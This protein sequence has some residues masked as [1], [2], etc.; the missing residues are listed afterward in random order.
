MLEELERED[1]QVV[2]DSGGFSDFE[3]IADSAYEPDYLEALADYFEA[4]FPD[5]L[6]PLPDDTAQRLADYLRSLTVEAGPPP[7]DLLE[8][9]LTTLRT[10]ALPVED[11][12]AFPVVEESL[13]KTLFPALKEVEFPPLDPDGV[14]GS[15]QA[16]TVERKVTSF[17][18]WVTLF[19]IIKETK[20]RLTRPPG[21][22]PSKKSWR[23]AGP[24]ELIALET[25]H[26]NR[27]I[28][29]KNSPDPVGFGMFSKQIN[30]PLKTDAITAT[31]SG[32][33]LSVGSQKVPSLQ[34][35]RTKRHGEVATS[36]VGPMHMHV[37]VLFTPLAAR[38]AKL[39]VTT[40]NPFVQWPISL[41]KNKTFNAIAAI[42][43]KFYSAIIR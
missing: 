41:L 33:M 7:E 38:I 9:L 28:Q 10:H 15:I 12:P 20:A 36:F 19:R 21:L 6:P 17:R 3:P 31:L 8:E 11:C 22:N 42:E 30:T 18:Q 14:E 16:I 39:E 2:L 37:D 4:A 34:A 43:L 13:R 40:G 35:L 5:G 29:L 27:S 1:Q 24:F 23:R 26:L 32:F 25:I